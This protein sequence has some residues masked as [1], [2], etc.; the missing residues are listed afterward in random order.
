MTGDVDVAESQ[1]ATNDEKESK[2]LDKY[3]CI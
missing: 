2:N 3:I 1:G